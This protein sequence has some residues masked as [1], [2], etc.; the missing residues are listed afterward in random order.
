MGLVSIQPISPTPWTRP[1]I[2]LGPSPPSRSYYKKKDVRP[3]VCSYPL[4]GCLKNFGV[5]W[6]PKAI[7]VDGLLEV[8]GAV[9]FAGYLRDVTLFCTCNRFKIAGNNI[10]FPL[11]GKKQIWR[12]AQKTLQNK[13][14]EF[15]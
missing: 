12:P 4:L 9:G 15:F 5:F 6:A 1:Q 8:A 7:A 3:F 11:C 2:L 14:K 10:K 13:N